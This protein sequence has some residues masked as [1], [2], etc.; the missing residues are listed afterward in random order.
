MK[1]K[2]LQ[3]QTI[4]ITGATS[5]IGLVTA[6]MA[7]ARGAAVVI[8]ARG[9]D[10]LSH[11][12]NELTNRG[13]RCAHVTA[14]VTSEEDLRRI[15]RVA[16]EQFGG[17][18]TWVN[19]A[20]GSIFGTCLDTPLEDQRKLFELN[21]WSV[22]MASRIAV[23]AMHER[24]GALINVGSIASDTSIPLQGTYS[25]TKHAVKAFTD[26]LRVE[27]E[28]EDVP[29]SVTLIK[30]TA[31]DTP[32]F[33]HAVSHMDAAP[34]APSPMYAPELV[35]E[36]ILRAAEVPTRDVLV[37]GTAV[38]QSALGRIAP[39]AGDLYSK[40]TMFTGQKSGRTRQPGENQILD[41]PSG[42][43][44]ERGHYGTRVMEHCPVTSAAMR[45]GLSVLAIAGAALGAMGLIQWAR[46]A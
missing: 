14:D 4:V 20:G 36:C 34:T 11:L 2:R 43:L 12:H 13:A 30:P 15:A 41:T 42:E 46:R 7:A 6:R 17:I 23:E 22:V 44:A 26:A 10:A 18:D 37:G 25:A 32:L 27:L 39:R 29:I 3:D 19:N 8:A 45:P 21:Y 28:H 9:S 5:G 38:V 35:A 1:L 40:K 33:R 16:Q 24:G 31:I